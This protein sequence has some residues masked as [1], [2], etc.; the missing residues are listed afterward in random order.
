MKREKGCRVFVFIWTSEG[1]GGNAFS[2]VVFNRPFAVTCMVLFFGAVVEWWPIPSGEM[3]CATIGR[4]MERG[5]R[6]RI[7]LY[8]IAGRGVCV[9]RSPGGTHESEADATV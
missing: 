9:V 5:E 8:H 3:G 1:Y 6:E 4:W 2:L 7:R